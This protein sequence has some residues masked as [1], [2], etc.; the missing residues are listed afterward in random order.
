MAIK[1]IPIIK[2]AIKP[3][4][5]YLIEKKRDGN[6]FTEEEVRFLVDSILDKEIPEYQMAALIMAIY[7]KD[8]S[9]LET[10]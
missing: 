5:A 8:M 3:S 7:F 9:A 4:Y 10:A 6:E 1:K 2:T